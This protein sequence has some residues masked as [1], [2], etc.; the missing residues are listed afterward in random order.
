MGELYRDAIG[1]TVTL[2]VAGAS[3]VDV[4]FVRAGVSTPATP[5]GLSAPIPYSITCTDGDFDTVWDYTVSGS[6]DI[7]TRVDR[8]TVVTPYFSKADLIAYSTIFASMTDQQAV[9][10]ERLVRSVINKVTSQDFGSKSGSVISYGTGDSILLLPEHCEQFIS[11]AY[12]NN[13]T[14]LLDSEYR[15]LNKGY[16]IE[17]VG[18][19]NGYTIKVPAYEEQF[20]NQVITPYYFLVDR[21]KDNIGYQVNGVFGYSSVPD[22]VV[23]AALIL[24]EALSHDETTWQDRYVGSIKAADWAIEFNGGRFGGTGNAKVDLILSKYIQNR[25]SII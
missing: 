5:S 25:I 17:Q 18:I 9:N 2:S 13:P 15:L 1:K 21:F 3:V 24:A 19:D 10:L 20:G 12:S 16:G 7:Y 14:V 6:P 4:N 22:D 11:L 23:L 8:N